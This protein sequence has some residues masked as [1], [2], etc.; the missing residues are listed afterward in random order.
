[1]KIKKGDKVKVMAGKDKGR[2]GTVEK[3]FSKEGK[4]LVGGVNMYKKHQKSRGGKD[5]GGII[6]ITKPLPAESLSLVCPKCGKV[7]RVGYLVDK[8][9][10]KSRIC[11]KCKEVI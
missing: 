4:I 7:V 9:G 8:S 6:D 3:V 1:M 11:K 2:T 10:S 5:K